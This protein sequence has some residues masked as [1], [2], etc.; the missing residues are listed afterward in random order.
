MYVTM[1][2]AFPL[3]IA[4]SNIVTLFNA[5]P[6][7]SLPLVRIERINQSTPTSLYVFTVKI[8]LTLKR[9]MLAPV[10]FSPRG[11]QTNRLKSS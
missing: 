5:R 1:G 7:T 3:L 6:L 8:T 10:S 4:A 9:S 2:I 11:K